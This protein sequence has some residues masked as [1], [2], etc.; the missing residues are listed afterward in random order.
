LIETN[1]NIVVLDGFWRCCCNEHW[2]RLKIWTGPNY[3]SGLIASWPLLKWVNSDLI[4]TIRAK[5]QIW[6]N[7]VICKSVNSVI[8]SITCIRDELIIWHCSNNV[9]PYTVT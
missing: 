2:V 8:E 4:Q 1:L 9:I 3:L 7:L 5:H 6:Q